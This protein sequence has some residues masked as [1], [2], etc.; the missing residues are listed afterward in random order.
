MPKFTGEMRG[1]SAATP[2]LCEPA[3][4]KCLWT[5][6][7]SHFVVKFTGDWPHTDATTSIQH[8]TVRTPQCG[9]TVRK[10]K[11][12]FGSASPKTNG[13]E[14]GKA[15]RLAEFSTASLK[16]NGFKQGRQL[17]YLRMV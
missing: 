1:V 5:C 9:H 8:R 13:F 12:S 15:M 2:V 3:Q 7:K 14:Q 17:C 6:H 11:H 16:T 4:S 10:I